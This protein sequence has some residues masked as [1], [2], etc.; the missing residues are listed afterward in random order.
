MGLRV[1]AIF[2]KEGGWGRG[3]IL[4]SGMPFPLPA[5]S[6]VEGL[7]QLSLGPGPIRRGLNGTQGPLYLSRF[8]T[9]ELVSLRLSLTE[10]SPFSRR[11]NSKVRGS[12]CGADFT[13]HQQPLLPQFMNAPFVVLSTTVRYNWSC[14]PLCLWLVSISPVESAPILFYFSCMDQVLTLSTLILSTLEFLWLSLHFSNVEFFG[15]KVLVG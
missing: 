8:A 4:V 7:T 6:L 10:F 15:N 2:F 5:L 11:N 3:Y 9:A 1:L 12:T 13:A 14:G